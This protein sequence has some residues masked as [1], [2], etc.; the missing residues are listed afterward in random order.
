MFQTWIRQE[1]ETRCIELYKQNKKS[2]WESAHFES[3]AEQR[4][5]DW[6]FRDVN[7]P[8]GTSQDRTLINPLKAL[9]TEFILNNIY[10]SSSYFTGNILRLRYK[11]QPVNAL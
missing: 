6:G 9:K 11:A 4:L 1:R 8:L 3:R 5:F 7:E 2:N 10:E